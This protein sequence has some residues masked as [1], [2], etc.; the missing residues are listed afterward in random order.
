MTNPGPPIE[1]SGEEAGRFEGKEQHGWAP[2]VGKE[3]TEEAHEASEKAIQGGG[4][5][6]GEPHDK[7]QS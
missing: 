2:D 4:K 5:A 7:T 3:G 6:E 1:D